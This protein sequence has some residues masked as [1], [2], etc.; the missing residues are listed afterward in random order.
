MAGARDSR[1]YESVSA[2]YP[3]QDFF[4]QRVITSTMPTFLGDHVC[5]GFNSLFSVHI[6]NPHTGTKIGAGKTNDLNCL[7]EC[8]DFDRRTILRR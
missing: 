5:E 6:Q 1:D 7:P 2:V 4:L 3:S 8:P